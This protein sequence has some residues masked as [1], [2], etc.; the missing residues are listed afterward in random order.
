MSIWIHQRAHNKITAINKQIV[1]PYKKTY[2]QIHHKPNIGK[3]KDVMKHGYK[4][5][6]LYQKILYK[7]KKFY[8]I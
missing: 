2:D 6:I 7:E 3:E 8:F 4:N 1:K 5:Y